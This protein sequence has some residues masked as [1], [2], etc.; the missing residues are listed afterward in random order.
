LAALLAALSGR[1]ERG[2]RA[3]RDHAGF[4]LGNRNLPDWSRPPRTQCSRSGLRRTLQA[5][6]APPGASCMQKA[7]AAMPERGTVASM[8]VSVDRQ[9]IFRRSG[10]RFA[11][12]NATNARILE[13]IP[14]PLNRNAL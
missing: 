9:S 12:E 5:W 2:F 8:K 4:K 7:A 13:R 6:T 1:R 10:R 11:A 14:I 3:R